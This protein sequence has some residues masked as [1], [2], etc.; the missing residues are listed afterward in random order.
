MT[1]DRCILMLVK[2]PKAGSVKSRLATT[3]GPDSAAD[4]Y[5]CFVNDLVRTLRQTPYHFRICY[6]P[7]DSDDRVRQWLGPGEEYVPQAGADLGERMK[8][9]F[10]EAFSGG[11]RHVLIIGSDSPDLPKAVLDEAFEAL[12]EADAVIGPSLDG[13]YY[14]IGFKDETF[15][16]QVFEQMDW[17][18]EV[19]LAQ[20]LERFEKKGYRVHLL[21]PWKDVDR[22][23]DLTTLYHMNRRTPFASSQTMV[24]ILHNLRLP[25]P[26]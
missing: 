24:Y 9:A 20:T 2:W 16:P 8:N 15:L 25:D 26:D 5:R 11:L 7:E 22:M 4:L 6:Y 18:T 19:V 12:M 23:E 3:I 17:G 21:P 13:G 14:L 1:A 10:L